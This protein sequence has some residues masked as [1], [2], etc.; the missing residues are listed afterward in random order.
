MMARQTWRPDPDLQMVY[1]SIAA[2]AVS[3]RLLLH[4]GVGWYHDRD[5]EG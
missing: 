2:I 4:A 1:N 3:W 5:P